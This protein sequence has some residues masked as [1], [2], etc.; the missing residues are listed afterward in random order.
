MHFNEILYFRGSAQQRN[1]WKSVFNKYWWDNSIDQNNLMHK[2]IKSVD[3]RNSSIN[4]VAK[5]YLLKASNEWTH[6][7]PGNR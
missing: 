4:D 1:P 7:L 6:Q 3:V 5:I 2:N